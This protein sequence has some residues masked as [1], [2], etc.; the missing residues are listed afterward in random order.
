MLKTCLELLRPED[1]FNT[2]LQDV[3]KTCLQDFFKKL[4]HLDVLE[5]NKMF[6][7]KESGSVSN[8]SKSASNKFMMH[9]SEPQNFDI[10]R[11][12]TLK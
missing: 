1:I 10:H 4:R 7:S 8:I 11:I 5:I 12:V 9:Y 2:C 6:N 3:F